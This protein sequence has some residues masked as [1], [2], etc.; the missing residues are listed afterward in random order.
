MELRH[1]RYFTAVAEE[2]HFG[3]AA[4]RLH[5]AQPPLSQHIL[6]LERELGVQLFARTR[7]KVELTDAGRVFLAEAQ[8]ILLHTE[9]AIRNAQRASRG[10]IGRLT[11]GFVL[12]ATCSLLPE[13]LRVFRE[14]FPTVELA[15]EEVTTG[16]GLAALR[17][18]RM[19][20]CFIRLPVP[21]LDA[22]LWLEPV[23]KEKILLA[24]P[25][26]HPLTARAKVPLRLL[27]N[28]PFIIFPRDQGSG[29]YDLLLRA[30]R[31]AGFTPQVA[32]EAGQMQTILSLVAAGL[33]IALIPSSVQSLRSNDVVY[34][35]LSVPLPGTGLAVAGRRNDESIMLKNFTRVV[36][37]VVRAKA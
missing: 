26:H 24:L 10:E 21:D 12:S 16:Q 22:A 27:S 6:H 18:A 37:E 31:Q 17:D 7:R 8:A 25:P 35:P 36:R 15:L 9:H 19:Q 20:L 23:L 34:K 32:Q 28:E 11:V 1:L 33:G 30:C 3:R 13:V 2:L 4:E 29:F 14:R 5:M